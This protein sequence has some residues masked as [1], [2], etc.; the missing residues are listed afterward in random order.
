MLRVFYDRLVMDSDIKWIF[1]YLKECLKKNF[2][3]TMDELCNHLRS[4][5]N[6]ELEADDL[7]SLL[8]CDFV[9]PKSESKAYVEVR[10][11][12]SL[13]IFEY[14]NN[15]P[16]EFSLFKFYRGITLGYLTPG[17]GLVVCHVSIYNQ[18]RRLD[19]PHTERP[20]VQQDNRPS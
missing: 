14:N 20:T 18:L 1:G 5:E 12:D 17:I 9:D 16:D 4:N 8:F 3:I 11:M 13:R 10:N 19:T 6:G 7:R 15:L 2:D